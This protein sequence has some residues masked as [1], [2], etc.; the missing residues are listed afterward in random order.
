MAERYIFDEQFDPNTVNP[1]DIEIEWF[2]EGRYGVTV[3]GTQDNPDF[4][5]DIIID[6][7][8]DKFLH[9]VTY[10]KHNNVTI[11]KFNGLVPS[12]IS[13]GK[14]NDNIFITLN[15]VLESIGISIGID[16]GNDRVIVSDGNNMSIDG[17]PKNYSYNPYHGPVPRGV[18]IT[19][20][21]QFYSDPNSN[22]PPLDMAS[23]TYILLSDRTTISFNDWRGNCVAI[24]PDTAIGVY[25]ENLP[26]SNYIDHSGFS[27]RLVIPASNH[28]T[29]RIDDAS[30]DEETWSERSDRRWAEERGEVYVRE[31]NTNIIIAAPNNEYSSIDNVGDLVFVGKDGSDVTID[32]ETLYEA[33]ISNDGSISTQTLLDRNQFSDELRFSHEETDGP[34]GTQ[35]FG[36]IGE[37]L[38]NGCASNK[39]VS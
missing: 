24:N 38:Q 17:E 7:N 12:F 21:L 20:E 15:D 37:A 36:P 29:L 32:R 2:K 31:P 39:F 8:P 10:A 18:D 13:S 11:T 16:G 26:D 9:I 3:G 1:D 33:M 23:K 35:R 14:S 6:D 34:E 19:E 4:S 30:H 28:Y 5:T 25:Y 22:E 27:D